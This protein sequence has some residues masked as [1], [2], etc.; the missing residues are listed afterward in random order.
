MI[1]FWFICGSYECLSIIWGDDTNFFD[2]TVV[3]LMYDVGKGGI[4]RGEG[5]NWAKGNSV[6]D[7]S[8]FYRPLVSNSNDI[9]EDSLHW[10]YAAPANMHGA[11]ERNGWEHPLMVDGRGII[12]E[13]I[14]VTRR[15]KEAMKSSVG[16]FILISC[17]AIGQRWIC[18]GALKWSCIVKLDV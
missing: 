10:G 3:K 11:E 5:W 15:M 8:H 13:M 2:Y 14:H 12:F 1:F 9:L 16:G 18:K 4:L 6:F 7:R 17:F